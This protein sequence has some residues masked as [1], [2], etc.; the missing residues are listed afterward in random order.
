MACWSWEAAW[1]AV[2]RNPPGLVLLENE[3][4]WFG[5]SQQLRLV[6]ILRSTVMVRVGGGWMALDEFLVKNDP[7]RGE[8]C[9][10][11]DGIFT[12]VFHMLP[13]VLSLCPMFASCF[14]HSQPKQDLAKPWSS[15]AIS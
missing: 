8:F 2:Q 9:S 11:P 3:L 6:R 13:P 15:N 5:D 14:L 1:R 4:R 7:C 10:N 12:I